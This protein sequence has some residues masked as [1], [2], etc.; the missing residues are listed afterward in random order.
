MQSQT[1]N[2]CPADRADVPRRL[3]GCMVKR[4][5][6]LV[7]ATLA[8]IVLSPL[9]ILIAALVSTSGGPVLYRH[10]RIGKNGKSF[11][12]LKF[13]TMIPGAT[14][15]LEEY[16]SYHPQARAEWEST[17]KLTFDPRATAVGR[18]LRRTSL[19]ELPQLFNVLMGDMSLVGPRPVTAPELHYYGDKA[20]LYRSVRPGITG[21]WQI[22]GRNDVSYE[23]RVAL[24]ARYVR[25]QSL[26]RDIAIL[27]RTPR[28]VLARTGAR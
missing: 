2:Y 28:V 3:L 5:M 26:W 21:L 6:D 17:R 14:E 23:Q 16:L 15:C 10:A 20:E 25:E 9:F 27:L 4:V 24:D 11:D 22:S 13:S 8:I 1:A 12:C 18:L 19:D 7:F